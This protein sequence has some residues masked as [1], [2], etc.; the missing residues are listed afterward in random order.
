MELSL[1]I[2]KFRQRIVTKL[3]Q[4]TVPAH[5]AL[6]TKHLEPTFMSGPARGQAAEE[7]LEKQPFH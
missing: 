3:S 1:R 7:K 6:K 2:L 4:G 5:T